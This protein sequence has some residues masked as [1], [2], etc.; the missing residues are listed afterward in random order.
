MP[1]VGDKQFP[2]TE[3]GMVAAQ[4]EAQATGLPIEEDDMA[5][6]LPQ[7]ET[8]VAEEEVPQEEP[9]EQAEP[10]KEDLLNQVY[11]VVF[12][13]PFEPGNEDA[14]EQM[15][16]LSDLLASDPKLTA[17]LNS[18]ELTISQFAVE[19]YRMMEDKRAAQAQAAQ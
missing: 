12:G 4:A 10:L 3:E 6:E 19:L 1:K 13:S 18:G 16:I 5:A 14:E 7:E 11:E 17:M 2:Y 9:T 8:E 15:S